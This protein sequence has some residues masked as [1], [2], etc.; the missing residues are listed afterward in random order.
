MLGLGS[1]WLI[2]WTHCASQVERL[3]ANLKSRLQQQ[4]AERLTQSG[5][6]FRFRLEWTGSLVVDAGFTSSSPLARMEMANGFFEFCRPFSDGESV[7]RYIEFV[8]E[9]GCVKDARNG[10]SRMLIDL[11]RLPRRGLHVSAKLPAE[12]DGV[13]S[14]D[15]K[16]HQCWS[17]LT[18]S[19]VGL[20]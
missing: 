5:R 8:C 4:L 7:E 10:Q 15:V 6:G 1:T 11:P 19:G 3:K 18:C 14:M 20:P 2:M 12:Q 9:G 17:Q 16:L 13:T